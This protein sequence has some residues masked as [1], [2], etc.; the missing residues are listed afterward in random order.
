MKRGEKGY[1]VENRREI[2]AWTRFEGEKFGLS[3][4][5]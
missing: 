5:G 2:D 1:N 4:V 3:E